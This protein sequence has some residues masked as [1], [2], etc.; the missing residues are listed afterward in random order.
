M[1]ASGLPVVGFTTAIPPELR[2]E[3]VSIA[4]DSHD[5]RDLIKPLEIVN[6]SEPEACRNF[7]ASFDMKKTSAAYVNVY[8]RIAK[9]VR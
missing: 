3:K 8:E 5:W 9:K 4:V 7:A 6:Q 2:N 1:L